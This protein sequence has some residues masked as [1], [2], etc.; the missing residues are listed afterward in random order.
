MTIYPD[1]IRRKSRHGGQILIETA[2]ITIAHEA[3]AAKLFR[4]NS[5]LSLYLDG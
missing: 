4:F 5:F 2:G 3:H 1:S